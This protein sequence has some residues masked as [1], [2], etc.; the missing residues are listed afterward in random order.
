MKRI[1]PN[2]FLGISIIVAMLIYTFANRYQ[3]SPVNETLII[4]SWSGDLYDIQGNNLSKIHK[5]FDSPEE[6][7]NP[8]PTKIQ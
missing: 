4:D 5:N 2:Y 8:N 6:F 7:S 1:Q 3:P